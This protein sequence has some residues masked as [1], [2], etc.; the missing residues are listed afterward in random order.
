M[1]FCPAG[2]PRFFLLYEHAAPASAWVGGGRS[3]SVLC[4]SPLSSSARCSRLPQI[5]LKKFALYI[6]PAHFHPLRQ[7]GNTRAGCPVFTL[8]LAFIPL[9]AHLRSSVETKGCGLR[10]WH[11]PRQCTT[12]GCNEICLN[13]IG[14]FW[15]N[16]LPPVKNP[17]AIRRKGR[18]PEEAKEHVN[19]TWHGRRQLSNCGVA[20][21]YP[22]QRL[23]V[24][25]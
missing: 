13:V 22:G 16:E 19:R 6:A 1:F 2:K 23:G 11:G 9:K 14:T 8:K 20:K 25:A 3:C 21:R 10:A 17:L 15:Q 7:R 12:A 5:N 4:W 24:M 18:W